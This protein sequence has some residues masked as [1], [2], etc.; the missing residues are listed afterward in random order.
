MNQNHK[1]DKKNIKNIAYLLYI[2]QNNLY[3]MNE[4]I[5]EFSLD[6][7]INTKNNGIIT[8]LLQYF[9]NINNNEQIEYILKLCNNCDLMKR[10]YLNLINYYYN[11]DINKSIHFLENN[12]LSQTSDNTNN[13]ILQKDIDF[14][15]ENKLFKI[16]EKLSGIFIETSVSNYPIININELNLKLLSITD[17]INQILLNSVENLLSHSNK[18]NLTHFIN[19][20][21]TLYNVIIDGGNILH[22]RQGQINKQSFNDL[23]IL[24]FILS[25]ILVNL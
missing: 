5:T 18:V 6:N 1:L 20:Q 8:N 11:I 4:I 7:L 3:I 19:K 21:T 14:I 15:I 25:K 13:I 12:V 17:S 24:L 23:K 9:I 10:D 16:L 22:A 2:N